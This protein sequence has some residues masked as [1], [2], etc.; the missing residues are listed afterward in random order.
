MSI[1]SESVNYLTLYSISLMVKKPRPSSLSKIIN[2]LLE[3]V[4]S[5][6]DERR[7]TSCLGGFCLIRM[8]IYVLIKYSS[9]ECRT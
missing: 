2:S 7:D 8:K 6:N 1:S 5:D 9:Q 4:S 3:D